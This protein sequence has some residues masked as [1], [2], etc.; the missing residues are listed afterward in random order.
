MWNVWNGTGISS[1]VNRLRWCCNTLLL[2]AT[3]CYSL[4]H[5]ATH[6][7]TLLHTATHCNTLQNT[8][9]H[10]NTLQHTATHCNTL[11]HIATHCNTLQ[12]TATHMCCALWHTCIGSRFIIVTHTC[13]WYD[14]FMPVIWLVGVRHTGVARSGIHAP[15]ADLSSWFETS[16][17][18]I[19]HWDHDC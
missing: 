8:A 19:G 6:C 13:V 4:L 7:Y 10:C 5:T 18:T 1:H 3:H 2:T 17:Y 9:T 12:R 14:S 16:E 15:A 11:Q